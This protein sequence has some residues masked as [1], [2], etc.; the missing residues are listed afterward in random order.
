[1]LNF[2]KNIITLFSLSLLSS[3]SFASYDNR[4]ISIED[5]KKDDIYG[6]QKMSAFYLKLQK[7]K[8]EFDYA[9]SVILG[10]DVPVFNQYLENFSTTYE[11]LIPWPTDEWEKKRADMKRNSG[12]KN[13]QDLISGIE[14]LLHLKYSVPIIQHQNFGSIILTGKVGGGLLFRGKT[15]K[16]IESDIGPEPEGFVSHEEWESYNRKIRNNPVFRMSFIQSGSV[17]V[18]YFPVEWIGI[19]FEFGAK[20]YPNQKDYVPTKEDKVDYFFTV[21]ARITY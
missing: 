1:M 11:V 13:D 21:G 4:E 7:P 3:L 20:Y 19:S 5:F 12:K 2:I 9:N 8:I 18:E 10:F 14:S 15:Q 16:E 17:G 6:P